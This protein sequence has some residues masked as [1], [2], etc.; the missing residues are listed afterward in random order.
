MLAKISLAS[1]I[2]DI[3]DIF[4]FHNNFVCDIYAPNKKIKCLPYLILTDTNSAAFILVSVCKIGCSMTEEESGKLIFK[5]NQ[6]CRSKV[7]SALN[8]WMIFMRFWAYKVLA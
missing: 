6:K 4:R 2:Y 5:I 3:I 8:C 7:R 1:F